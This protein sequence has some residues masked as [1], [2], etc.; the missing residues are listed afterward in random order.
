MLD[1]NATEP[2]CCDGSDEPYGVCPN[3]CKRVG[4]EHRKRVEEEMKLRKTVRCKPFTQI[5][6]SSRR[7]SSL[8]GSKIRSSYIAFAKKEKTR[9]EAALST[10]GREVEAKTKE[11]A[12]LKGQL[13]VVQFKHSY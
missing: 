1:E 12:R 6:R 2:E 13:F 7:T 5:G 11:V 4:E 10:N 3:I 9:L 8:Q